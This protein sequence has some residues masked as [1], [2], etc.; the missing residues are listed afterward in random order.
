[1]LHLPAWPPDLVFPG[2][3]YLVDSESPCG[4][5][6]R[7]C[8]K[9]KASRVR[10]CAYLPVLCSLWLCP[11]IPTIGVLFVSPS[12]GCLSWALAGDPWWWLTFH[13]LHQSPLS[14]ESCCVA[15][16]PSPNAHPNLL[17]ILPFGSWLGQLVCLVS[18]RGRLWPAWTAWRRLTA[19]SLQEAPLVF[20]ILW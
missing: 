20:C 17:N 14:K 18:I 13:S 15:W 19:A 16:V 5:W 12:P 7:T 6:A 2:V 4:L 10:G 8:L 1:M 3:D 9:G 11:R